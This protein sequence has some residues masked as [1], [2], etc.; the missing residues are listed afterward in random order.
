MDFIRAAITSVEVAAGGPDRVG[1]HQPWKDRGELVAVREDKEEE[2]SGVVRVHEGVGEGSVWVGG[3]GQNEIWYTLPSCQDCQRNIVTQAGG[4]SQK[5]VCRNIHS[6]RARP[7][8]HS[9]ALRSLRIQEC[10]CVDYGAVRGWRLVHLHP[11]QSHV[12]VKQCG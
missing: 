9:Q 12:H 5:T 7:P 6:H 4:Q 8:Q 3:K 1:S 10:N 2:L 11:L